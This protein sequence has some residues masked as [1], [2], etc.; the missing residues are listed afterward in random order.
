M[1]YEVIDDLRLKNDN[2]INISF[3][4]TSIDYI[5][6]G[7][8]ELPNL[9]FKDGLFYNIAN[10]NPFKHKQVTVVAVIAETIFHKDVK[11]RLNPDLMYQDDSNPIKN[12]TATL[13]G[14]EIR[15]VTNYEN[16]REKVEVRLIGNE[17]EIIFNL[18]F[19]DETS[20]QTIATIN[21]SLTP[22][23]NSDPCYTE[24]FVGESGIDRNSSENTLPFQGYNEI[25]PLHGVLEY[26][27]YF[28]KVTNNSCNSKK[29]NKPVV[30]LDGFDPGDKRNLDALY[31]IMVYKDASGVER[32]FVDK[33]TA[34]QSNC[35]FDV[36]LVNF[37]QNKIVD[38][39]QPT[40][41][42]WVITNVIAHV[43]HMP[44]PFQSMTI[45]NYEEVGHWT[46]VVNYQVLADGG[47][48]YIERNA[49]ALVALL[50]RENKK[51]ADNGSSEKIS[52]IGSSMGGLISRYALAYMEKNNIPHN[53]KLW[54][55]FDSPHLGA[56]IPISAQENI[57]FF[58]QFGQK[59]QAK[60]KFHE[61][62]ASPAARQMLIEQLDYKHQNYSWHVSPDLWTGSIY[63]M[64][65]SQQ[66]NDT[67]PLGQNNSSPFRAR[68]MNELENLNG[69]QNS[70]GF[71]TNV[72]KIALINGT[73][74]GT[75]TNSEAQTCL[76]LAGFSPSWNKAI[77]FVN[78]NL[79]S[80]NQMV[81]TFSGKISIPVKMGQI[82]GTEIF[83]PV[84]LIYTAGK[85]RPNINPRGSMDVVQG[86][87]FSTQ[88]I[89]KDEFSPQ[90]DEAGVEQQWRVYKPNHCFIP[91]VSSLAFKN[92]NFDWSA[93]I[94][95]NLLCDTNN[96][97]I[98]F[99]SYFSPSKNEEHVDL[100]NESV[101]WLLAEIQ[102]MPQ[103]PSFS[104]NENQLAG[105]RQLCNNQIA[106][107]GFG[108]DVCKLPSLVQ[109]WTVSPN[110]QINSSNSLNITVK[111]NITT[112]GEEGIITANFS[113]AVK[114]EIHVWIG[115][116][117]FTY[118]YTYYDI[119]PVKSTLCIVSAEPNMTLEQ[120]GVTN[121]TWTGL[122]AVNMICRKTTSPICKEA[123]VT[124]ACGSSKFK[125]NCDFSKQSA[126]NNYFIVYPN[127]TM[128]IVNIEL[129]DKTKP[130][131]ETIINSAQLFDFMGQQK[132]NIQIINDKAIFNVQGY[133]KGIY[134]LR[135]NTPNGFENHYISVN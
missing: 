91:A 127:P 12:L 129:K 9:A 36:T 46:T 132:Q 123:T 85:S 80:Q 115:K 130:Q 60:K 56:N 17:K 6:Y 95:R 74:N 2:V 135:I 104:I 20:I 125:Y 116:P 92:S 37:P 10:R 5:D 34:N 39:T 66:P 106:N 72:R 48:D 31:S 121:V 67:A 49:M 24:D 87:T 35:G 113:S 112:D 119:Q 109:S 57:Y 71:P 3:I 8:K 51:L 73:T 133:L 75:K 88:K 81:Q 28:N 15:L 30:I 47:A 44:W 53:V 110:L 64:G 107:Y 90:L 100:T 126:T 52:L 65:F 94:N 16:S 33:L 86:G 45:T 25:S 89:I 27:T 50:K 38:P 63:F 103:K 18:E 61:N 134:L 98:E 97:E 21:V 122:T 7:T 93:P 23:T 43:T 70:K 59:E 84:P 29:I 22:L 68:F 14:T 128:D 118:Q 131:D 13:N 105:P 55:S 26:R 82:F 1:Q 111:S 76:E 11:I 58:G 124:N 102:D 77:Y 96:K 101:E 42:V 99:D 120:Q 54:V 19:R 40:R 117:S 78:N 62:F 108:N 69:V 32:N 83:S 4:N 79:A 114:Y 41:Q